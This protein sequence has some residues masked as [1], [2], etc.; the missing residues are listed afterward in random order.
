M[1][2]TMHAPKLTRADYGFAAFAL[3]FSLIAVAIIAWILLGRSSV[4]A[5]GGLDLSFLPAVNA[6]LNAMA[7]ALLTLGWW[8]IRRKNQ[9]LHQ[10]SML[11]AFAMSSLFL[12]SYLTYHYVHGDTRYP[13]SEGLDRTLYLVLLASHV[14]LSVPV[15]PMALFAFYFAYRKQ[16]VRHRKVTRW[17]A[18]IWLY[19]SVTGVLVFLVLRA[20]LAYG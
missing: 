20:K 12:V 3:I 6:S 18:P 8:A 4:P 14:I 15:V 19:V 2:T 7:A 11:G 17:L 1:S 5:D 10:R 16:F 9:A 13:S